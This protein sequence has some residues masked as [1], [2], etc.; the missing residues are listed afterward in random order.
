MLR[1]A[2]RRCAAASAAR[3]VRLNYQDFP[4]AAATA[5]E[6]PLLILHGLF[7]SSSNFRSITKALCRRRR[8]VVADLR[9]HGASEW[10][11]DCS[12]AAMATDVAALLDEL[13]LP[14][15]ALCGH[16]L[17]GKAPIALATTDTS[18]LATSARPNAFDHP[19]SP[20][21][22]VSPLR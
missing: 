5:G 18:P 15:V 9:N 3:P 20:A 2:M 10:A 11:D 7:G 12:L 19:R 21:V 16:S 17:G 22:A 8:V 4:C 14:R 1:V 6:P 13:A